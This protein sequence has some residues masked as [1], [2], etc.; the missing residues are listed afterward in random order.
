MRVA[1]TF[2]AAFAFI[3][4]GADPVLHGVVRF[5]VGASLAN[6]VILSGDAYW[7]PLAAHNVPWLIAITRSHGKNCLATSAVVGEQ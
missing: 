4:V 6:P 3:E 7:M 2:L 1:R 5:L